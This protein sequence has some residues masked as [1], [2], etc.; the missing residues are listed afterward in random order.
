MEYNN[1]SYYL[2]DCSQNDLTNIV[3]Y[4]DRELCN[5]DAA[6]S[7]IQH[8]EKEMENLCKFPNIGSRL[9]NIYL[10]RNDICK[11]TVKNYIVYYFVEKRKNMIVVVRIG[12]SL[13][14]QDNLL[15]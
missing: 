14:N 7:F 5:R 10:K 6:I 13:Q 11:V 4:I 15:K 2:T 12:H 9:N 8:F 3:E 1:F